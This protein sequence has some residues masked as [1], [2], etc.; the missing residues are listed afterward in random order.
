MHE[1][2]IRDV[3][4]DGS[5]PDGDEVLEVDKDTP[6][7]WPI[8]WTKTRWGKYH[9]DVYLRSMAHGLEWAITDDDN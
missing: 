3:R 6:I 9:A 2:I 1:L 8:L 5:K 7:S 4:L